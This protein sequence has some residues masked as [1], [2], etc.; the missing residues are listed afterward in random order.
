MSVEVVGP[1]ITLT[2]MGETDVAGQSK[3]IRSVAEGLAPSQ[4]I[5]DPPPPPPSRP[6]PQAIRR[7]AQSTEVTEPHFPLGFRMC[8]RPD[9]GDPNPVMRRSDEWFIDQDRGQPGMKSR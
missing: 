1:I 2:A 5:I 6:P 9:I 8:T 7:K 3:R 4:S